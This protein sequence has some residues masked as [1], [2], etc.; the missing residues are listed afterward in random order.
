MLQ[1][2]LRFSYFKKQ[3]LIANTSGFYDLRIPSQKVKGS[4]VYKLRKKSRMSIVS[5]VYSVRND[6][7][8][9]VVRK[10]VVRTAVLLT[11]ALCLS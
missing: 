3:F 10:Y 7:I 4:C 5:A 2:F 1:F 11:P 9:V 6:S 8:S